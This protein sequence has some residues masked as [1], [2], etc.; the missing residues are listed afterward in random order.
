MAAAASIVRLNIFGHKSFGIKGL[1]A[2]KG[3]RAMLDGE[4]ANKDERL[5]AKDGIARTIDFTL[6]FT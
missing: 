5:N 4:K 6:L 1:R 2:E 3:S